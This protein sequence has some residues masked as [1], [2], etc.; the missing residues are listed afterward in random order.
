MPQGEYSDIISKLKPEAANPGDIVHIDGRV[1][2]RHEGIVHYTIGQRRGIGVA[3]AI[4]SMSYIS[5][6][7]MRRVIVGPREALE[8]RKAILRN[9]NWLG[10]DALADI[11]EGGVEVYAKVR[12]P[13]RPAGGPASSER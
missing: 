7:A 1:L 10:D 4:R 12:L 13:A 2:G 5:M 11:P 3:T 8:T 9:V 6:R